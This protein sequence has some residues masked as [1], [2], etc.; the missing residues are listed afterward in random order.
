MEL[1]EGFNAAAGVWRLGVD[2][3]EASASTAGE[4]TALN[5]RALLPIQE[6][7]MGEHR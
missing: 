1:V 3:D 5:V 2:A 6:E 7:K 4:E